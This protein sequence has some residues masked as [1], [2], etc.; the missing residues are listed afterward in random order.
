MQSFAARAAPLLR[1]MS[2]TMSKSAIQ[3]R[4]LSSEAAVDKYK[5]ETLKVTS[6]DQ[7]IYHVEINRPEK[8]NAMNPAFWR[9]MRECFYQIAEDS[10]CR[11]VMLSGAGKGFSSG[12]DFQEL[13]GLSGMMDDSIDVARKAYMIKKIIT[14]YQESFTA[15]EKCPKVVFAA[16]H[17]FCVGGGIN[18]ITACDIRYCTTDAFFQIKEVDLGIAAD[19]GVLQ[20]MPKVVGNDSLVRELAFTGRKIFAGE[21]EKIGL[22]SRVFPD[23]ESMQA[24]VLDTAKLIAGKSPVAVQGTKVNLNYSR[25]YPTDQ[26]LHFMAHYNMCMLQSEDVMKSI[27]ALMDK[28][29]KPPTFSKL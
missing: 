10:D 9:E 8:L 1:M 29:G 19:V 2:S 24:A 21:A 15:I 22:V 5:F 20:R 28:S 18:L 7:Y 14:E 6:P 11:V 3:T 12:L 17:N 4:L 16:V 27:M 23:K 26:A 13:G 25:S